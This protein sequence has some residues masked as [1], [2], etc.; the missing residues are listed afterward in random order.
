MKKKTE[1]LLPQVRDQN[2]NQSIERSVLLNKIK[3][4]LNRKKGGSELSRK[5]FSYQYKNNSVYHSWCKSQTPPLSIKK[6]FWAPCLP[7]IAFKESNVF[8]SNVEARHAVPLQR[9]NASH[10]K[11]SL[12]PIYFESSGTTAVGK[13][14][15][16]RHSFRSLELY[17]ISVIEGWKWFLQESKLESPREFIGFM[18]SFAEKP[19]S[20]LSC[21]V[22]ILMKE[23]GNDQK[24]WC[25]EKDRWIWRKLVRRLRDLEKQNRP[26]VLFGAAFGWVHFLDWCNE[27]KFQFHLSPKSIVIETGGYKGKSREMERKD[28][29][30]QLS[31]VFHLSL[32]QI[33]SEYSMCELSSQAYSFQSGRFRFPPW[34]QHR[35]VYP[36][37][38]RSVSQ[39]KSGVLE[40]F[41]PAN[42]DSCSWIRTEDQ[43][44][45]WKD[46]FEIVGRLPKAGLKG[47]SLAFEGNQK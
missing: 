24:I 7:I 8:A 30:S 46:S 45:S 5:I 25:M 3:T 2:D 20:S 36:L 43:A 38:S 28:L 4:F 23:F 22:D 39:G 19:H 17:R 42:L 21:M 16:S 26:C 29:H 1:I 13:A 15:V 31:K 34:C 40:I 10:F 33:R 6:K 12:P 37:S 27:N 44:I 11:E 32:N 35:V 9:K 14:V 41:D 18:P 47:C